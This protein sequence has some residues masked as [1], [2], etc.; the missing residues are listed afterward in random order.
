MRPTSLSLDP[1][2]HLDA[3][4]LEVAPAAP[5]QE[6]APGIGSFGELAGQTLSKGKPRR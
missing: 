3:A 4:P 2:R 5:G 1:G 6:S